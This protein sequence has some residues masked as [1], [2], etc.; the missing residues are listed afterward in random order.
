MDAAIADV[1]TRFY[2]YNKLPSFDGWTVY[3]TAGQSYWLK[4]T[5]GVVNDTSF[6][7]R[8]GTDGSEAADSDA[9]L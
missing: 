3:A 2:S 6:T 1:W 7:A 5:N 9:V 8:A 4:D